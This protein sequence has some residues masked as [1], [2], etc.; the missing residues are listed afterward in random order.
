[1]SIKNLTI[2]EKLLYFNSIPKLKIVNLF[3]IFKY[4]KKDLASL[5]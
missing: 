3:L 1:M 5:K 4:L 2:C